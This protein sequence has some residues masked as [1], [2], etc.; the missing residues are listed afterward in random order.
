MAQVI[1]VVQPALFTTVPR[2]PN[3]PIC[4]LMERELGLFVQSFNKLVINY[5]PTKINL[6]KKA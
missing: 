3:R 2:E 1:D 6:K 4:H 5:T